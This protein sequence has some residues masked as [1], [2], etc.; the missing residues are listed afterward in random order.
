MLHKLRSCHFPS[1]T[2]TFWTAKNFLNKQKKRTI[3]CGTCIAFFC[4]I[5]LKYA[6]QY[7]QQ[8]EVIGRKAF[9]LH[10]V[11][12]LTEKSSPLCPYYD[13]IETSS[14]HNNLFNKR[15][16]SEGYC[17]T[18]LFKFL[19][20]WNKQANWS[21]LFLDLTGLNNW[22]MSA[23][24]N[25]DCKYNHL[26]ASSYVPWWCGHHA[27]DAWT[28]GNPSWLAANRCT[29]IYVDMFKNLRRILWPHKCMRRLVPRFQ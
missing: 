13:L 28:T 21:T 23:C 8:F 7:I 12:C 16:P 20:Y 4:I 11:N 2:R 3:F 9:F 6:T 29:S 1:V 10:F 27:L 15:Y 24:R 17:S 26:T 25:I 14:C 19:K 22:S 5:K 18:R